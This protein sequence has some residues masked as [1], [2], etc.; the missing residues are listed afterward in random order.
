MKFCDKCNNKMISF[1]DSNTL[2][3][4]CN[5]CN[6][7]V[8]NDNPIVYENNYKQDYITDVELSIKADLI[9]DNSLKR[10][11]KHTCPNTQC[12]NT[13]NNEI[14]IVS[15]KKTL[16]NIYMCCSCLTEWKYS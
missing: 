7:I 14:I 9:Y 4:K 1:E 11:K 8:D 12:K 10:S 5:D 15:E 3:Y 13:W 16:Q 2:K 6:N